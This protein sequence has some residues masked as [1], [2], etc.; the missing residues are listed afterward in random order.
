M[1]GSLLANRSRVLAFKLGGTAQ[2]PPAPPLQ[3][4]GQP[5]AQ[6]IPDP[7]M[8]ATGGAIFG[9]YCSVCHGA[10]AVAGGVLPDLRW[11]PLLGSP[12]A[13]RKPVLEGSRL[14]QGMPDYGKVLT[15]EYA[16][17]VRAY[18]IARANETMPE[19]GRGDS[20]SGPRRTGGGTSV[21]IGA[22]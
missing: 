6:F 4:P 22:G 7:K 10:G 13:F 5:P 14:K 17:L 16:E 19:T 2:L 8:I 15:P 18:L 11:T 3:A 9:G 20:G 12:E 21:S 1:R